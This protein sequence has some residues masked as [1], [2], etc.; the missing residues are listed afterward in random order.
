M[1]KQRK[2]KSEAPDNFPEKTWNKLGETWRTSAMSKQTEELEQE[3]LKAVRSMA[4]T[5]HDQK[6]DTKLEALIKDV[7][8]RKSF[9]TETLAI[10]KAK[11]DFCIYLMN[12]RGAPVSIDDDEEETE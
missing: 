7:R 2:K 3:I 11:I 8:E 4:N 6:T 5:S 1:Q 10:E 9:Y 12:D